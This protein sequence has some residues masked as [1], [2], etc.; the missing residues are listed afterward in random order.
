MKGKSMNRA[1][2]PL[3][4]VTALV[5][6]ASSGTHRTVAAATAQPVPSISPLATP[7]AVGETP[8]PSPSGGMQP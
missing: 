7:T 2:V 1:V 8:Q 6:A 3:F 4:F 5:F